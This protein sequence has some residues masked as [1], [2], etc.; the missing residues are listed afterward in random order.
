LNER[1]SSLE[2]ELKNAGLGSGMTIFLS[3]DSANSYGYEDR[4]HNEGKVE[5]SAVHSKAF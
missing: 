2:I 4:I 3:D 5:P 1:S